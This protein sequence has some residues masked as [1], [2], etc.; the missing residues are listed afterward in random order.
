MEYRVE[1]RVERSTA[2][3]PRARCARVSLVAAIVLM[4][5]AGCTSWR[6]AGLYQRGTQ[7]LERG[8]SERAVG[9]LEQ[10]AQLAP[11]ASEVRNHLG[12]A[13]LAVGREDLALAS[14]E[15]ATQLDCD[16][17]AARD[18]LTRLQSHRVREAAIASVSIPRAAIP[19][20]PTGREGG[21]RGEG[22]V[23]ASNGEAP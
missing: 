11:E 7:A 14:F 10:A 5:A 9:L 16:N 3:S 15:L 13:Q 17:A 12:L 22:R 21:E 19:R 23:A 8:D 2:P 18:N 6:A 4:S 20:G 1:Y